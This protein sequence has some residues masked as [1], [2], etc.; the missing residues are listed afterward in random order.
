M[1]PYR[2]QARPGRIYWAALAFL[3]GF[4][5]LLIFICY[6]YL[7]PAL[8][9]TQRATP[10]EKKQ[11]AAHAQLLLA[12]ILV[13]LFAGMLLTFRVGRFFLPRSWG[14]P[15]KTKYVDAWAEA[16]KRMQTPPRS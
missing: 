10:E 14:K 2:C 6:T 4:A 12:V 11:L 15:M 16:G 8:E 9:A 1:R 5:V 7:F 13:I 3:T